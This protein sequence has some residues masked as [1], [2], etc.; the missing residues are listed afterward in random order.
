MSMKLYTDD[1][2]LELISKALDLRYTKRMNWSDIADNISIAR[3]TLNEWRKLDDWKDADARWRRQLRDD[4]RGDSSQLL[5]LAVQVIKEL[6]LTD[7]SGYVRLMS[8]SK[9]IDMNQVG[10]ELEEKIVDQSKELND[11]LLRTERKKTEF[12]RVLPGGLLPT[13]IQEMNQEYKE[14]K[15]QESKA[16]EAEYTLIKEEEEE[17][18]N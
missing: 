9:L 15:L 1:M 13:E 3:S 8:A 7:K 6:M 12:K 17:L 2:R 4:A 11:F 14:R 5:E 10:M 18:E 16:L